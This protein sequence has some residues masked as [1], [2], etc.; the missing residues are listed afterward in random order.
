M[1]LGV[2]RAA[3]VARVVDDN[4]C[5]V[6]ATGSQLLLKVSQ[7]HFP[8]SL[9]LERNRKQWNGM[10]LKMKTVEWNGTEDENGGMEWN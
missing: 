1:L 3:R 8:I 10:E 4:S 6:T 5:Y 7:I 2:D 9:R